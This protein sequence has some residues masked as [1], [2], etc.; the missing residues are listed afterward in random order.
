MTRAG[1]ETQGDAN[2]LSVIDLTRDFFY[3]SSP[4]PF[5][6][7]AIPIPPTVFVGAAVQDNAFLGYRAD[8][9]RPLVH[10]AFLPSGGSGLQ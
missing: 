9:W 10:A 4:D 5:G 2:Y 8:V 7:I 1:V 3:I 6:I